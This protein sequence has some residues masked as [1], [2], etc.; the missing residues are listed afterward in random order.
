MKRM[1]DLPSLDMFIASLSAPL[2]GNQRWRLVGSVQGLLGDPQFYLSRMGCAQLLQMPLLALRSRTRLPIV[3]F[4]ECHFAGTVP[5]KS[6]GAQ[7]WRTALEVLGPGKR[8]ESKEVVQLW[9]GCFCL[10]WMCELSLCKKLCH[11]S[12]LSFLLPPLHAVPVSAF[13]SS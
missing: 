9:L 3:P 1:M 2:N 8:D 6:L 7:L 12:S 10:T 4:L 5:P 13:L 11:L